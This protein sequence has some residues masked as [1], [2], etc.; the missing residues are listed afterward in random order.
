L[1]IDDAGELIFQT[2]YM[3]DWKKV[4]QTPSDRLCVACGVPMNKVE[5]FRDKKGLVYEGLVCH[6]CKSL[7]W[8]RASS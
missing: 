1:E 4:Q 7:F 2:Y 3:M 6:G 8:L 5:P